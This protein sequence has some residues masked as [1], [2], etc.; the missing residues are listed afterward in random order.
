M[1][2][3]LI[4]VPDDPNQPK[5]S[6]FGWINGYKAYL[7]L[8]ASEAKTWYAAYQGQIS[9]DTAIDISLGL[10]LAA[11][12]RSALKTST[13]QVAKAITDPTSPVA[14]AVASEAQPP[15]A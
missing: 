8:I 12:A 11:A 5:F 14:K 13:A 9:V 7:V 10:A 1:G 2:Y 3:Q 15:P 4:K 6:L